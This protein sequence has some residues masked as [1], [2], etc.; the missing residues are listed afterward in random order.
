[1]MDVE[2]LPGGRLWV[3]I[4]TDDEN[5]R[6]LAEPAASA[7]SSSAASSPGDHRGGWLP[8]YLHELLLRLLLVLAGLLVL[9]ILVHVR[10]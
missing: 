3:W 8:N 5:R 7:G 6:R 4:W 9:R 2:S 10:C 1:M